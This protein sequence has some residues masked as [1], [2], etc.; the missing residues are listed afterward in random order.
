MA[1]VGRVPYKKS[2]SFVF[3]KIN[4]L[5]L[6]REPTLLFCY[7]SVSPISA[8]PSSHPSPITIPSP[9]L[10]PPLKPS[11]SG[12]SAH[13][14][15]AFMPRLGGTQPTSRPRNS[16]ALTKNY[17]WELRAHG[18]DFQGPECEGR[19]GEPLNTWELGS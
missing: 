16:C 5:A 2:R 7:L 12:G 13:P 9:P 1:S 6:E 3:H 19:R 14:R 11:S 10:S 15:C 4:D 8:C 18:H 17:C